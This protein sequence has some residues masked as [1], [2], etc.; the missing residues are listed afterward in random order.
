MN[1]SLSWEPT[2][3]AAEFVTVFI[4]ILKFCPCVYFLFIASYISGQLK[5]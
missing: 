1:E 5:Q 4:F 2:E 3:T